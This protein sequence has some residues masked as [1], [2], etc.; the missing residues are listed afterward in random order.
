MTHQ[1][2]VLAAKPGDLSSTP[3]VPPGGRKEPDLSG[4]PPGLHKMSHTHERN[5]KNII[6]SVWLVGIVW[7]LDGGFSV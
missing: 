2:T 6:E 7:F 1:L 5:A 3:G 4:C